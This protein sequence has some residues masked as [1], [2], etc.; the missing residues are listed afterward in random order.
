MD[1]AYFK[2]FD[3]LNS[4]IIIL[5]GDNFK[6]LWMNEAAKAANWTG[7]SSNFQGQT[8]SSLLDEDTGNQINR[9]L[10]KTRVNSGAITRRD[11]EITHQ[12]GN[13]RSIDLTIN[14]SDKENLVFVEAVSIDN[15]NK[16]IDSTRSFSTQKNSSWLSKNF[17]S[18]S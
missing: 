3:N 18:R 1:F 15:L 8:I 16:I 5:D 12:T 11:F 10:Q 7:D 14:F 17:S 6:L 4:E 13:S 9:I 2:A